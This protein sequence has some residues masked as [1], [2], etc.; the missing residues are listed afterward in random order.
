[1]FRCRLA[2]IVA[3]GAVCA[4]SLTLFQSSPLAHTPISQVTWTVDIAPIIQTRCAN[5]H[6]PGGF[7]PMPLTTYEESREWAKAIRE[8]VLSGRMPPWQ[9]ARGYGDFANDASLTPLEIELLTSWADGATPHGGAVA[10]R[11]PSP[12]TS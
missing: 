2:V 12:K 3:T 1:M 7:G 11:P 9:A 6:K 8:E 10:Q 4:T 5:C